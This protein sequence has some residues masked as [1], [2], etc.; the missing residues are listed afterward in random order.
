VSNVVVVGATS[1]IAEAVV[2]EFARRKHRIVLAG[3][4]RE[5]IERTAKDVALRY[6]VETFVQPFD[7]E[8]SEGFEAFYEGVRGQ[9]GG[10]VDGIIVCHG[11][12]AEDAEA[13]RSLE[14]TRRT[15]DVNLTSVILLL[16]VVARDMEAR[17]R[18]W[19]A[20]VSSVAGDRGRQ[21]N[22]LYGA[23]KAGLNAYLQGLRNRLHSAGVHV[24]TIKPGFVY[25]KLTKDI[26]DPKSPLV[27]APETVARDISKA[28]DR[29]RNVLYTPWFWAH[30]MRIIR[31]IPE[32]VFKRLRL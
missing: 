20:A 30:I 23:S 3:R 7:A 24:L 17:E 29:R 27:A 26:L 22:Y 12:M 6:Q 8:T 11:F 21:S 14:L 1:G 25:T 19:I 4:D 9:L 31:W 32:P 13:R 15:I 10:E 28:I 2:H 16:E 5:E 18:G